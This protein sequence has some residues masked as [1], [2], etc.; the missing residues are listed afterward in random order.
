MA[1]AHIRKQEN[2]PGP[3]N[4]ARLE[5]VWGS[6]MRQAYTEAAPT[7][8]MGGEPSSCPPVSRAGAGERDWRAQSWQQ[9]FRI[10]ELTFSS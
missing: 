2:L 5:V 3:G 10:R 7:S 1:L 4:Y 8:E 9:R 6:L